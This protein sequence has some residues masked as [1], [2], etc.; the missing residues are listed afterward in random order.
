MFS[1]FEERIFEDDVIKK[2]TTKTCLVKKK[3]DWTNK[4]MS[5]SFDE[6]FSSVLSQI[7]SATVP[8]SRNNLSPLPLDDV[9]KQSEVFARYFIS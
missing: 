7:D 9:L 6:E 8:L 3:D 4:R 1:R 2:R 5:R